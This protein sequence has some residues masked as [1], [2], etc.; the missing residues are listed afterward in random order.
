MIKKIVI[1]FLLS[2]LALLCFSPFYIM[3]INSTHSANELLRS[4]FITPGRSFLENYATVNRM[5]DIRRGFLNSFIITISSTVLS[6]YFGALTA[7]G[8]AKYTFKGRGFFYSV[9]VGSMMIPSQLGIIGFFRL[10]S[11][12]GALDT[13]IPLIVPSAANA[14]TVFFIVQYMRSALP[15]SLLEAARIEGCGEFT[16]FNY[17]VLVLVKPAIATMSI[18]N[19]IFSWNNFMTPMI[20]LFS[21]KNFTIP[22]LIMNLRGTFNR[23][24]GATYCGIAISIIPILITY[25]C[26]SRYITSGLTAGAIKG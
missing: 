23:D 17:I 12:L 5:I 18:F 26:M 2:L 9:V 15:D 20:I 6:A 8:L 13:F 24:F 19:F 11:A 7:F 3:I 22:L 25:A 10:N 4:I 16:I 1:L 14:S 21:Q